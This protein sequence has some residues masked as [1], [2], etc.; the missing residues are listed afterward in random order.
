[1]ASPLFADGAREYVL[2]EKGRTMM[3][4]RSIRDES[5]PHLFRYSIA[6]GLEYDDRTARRMVKKWMKQ[7]PTRRH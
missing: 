7:K 1:M 5:D 2:T 4:R 3:A 6:V